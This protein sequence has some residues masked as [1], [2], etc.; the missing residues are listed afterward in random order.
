MGPDLE[1]QIDLY[2]RGELT[3]VEARELAQEALRRPDLFEE[4]NAAALAKAAMERD[5]NSGILE[6]YLSGQLSPEEERLLAREALNSEQLFD[7]L[8]AHG[9]VEQ[10]LED[11]EFR[12]AV[13]KAARPVQPIRPR[14][15]VRVFAIAGS[16]AAA[17]AFFTVYLKSP[18][19]KHDGAGITASQT[20]STLKPTLDPAASAGQPILL[21][22]QLRPASSDTPIFRGSEP[23]S[24]P[25]LA[26]GSILAIEEKIP[27]INLGSIDGLAKGSELR[28]LR[29]G[30]LIGRIVVTT[31]FRDRARGRIVEGETIRAGDQVRTDDSAY[32]SAVSQQVDALTARGDLKKAID[33]A[34]KAMTQLGTNRQLLER[35]ATLEYQTGALDAA[36]QHY[37]AAA[38]RET[39]ALNSLA[40]LYLLR[41]DYQRAETLLSGKS[42]AESL[43]NLGV[44]SEL[45]GDFQ[46]AAQYYGQA[47]RALDGAAAKS[48]ELVEKNLTRVKDLK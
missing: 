27:T 17:V 7:A 44:A 19:S 42:D 8:A 38:P 3:P 34:Q 20:Q 14:S 4:L 24:R 21:A 29:D 47:L 28:V 12:D 26:Q 13:S 22:S 46:K 37:E 35:I 31:V 33:V 2:A 30:Q 15:K 32:L 11:A 41:G 36:L 23:E 45:R 9:A 25:P 39:E 40:S 18:A 16:I 1:H 43:N 5:S 10:G 6:R 48:R